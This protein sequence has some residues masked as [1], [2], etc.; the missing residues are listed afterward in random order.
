M[1]QTAP[2][3]TRLIQ[4]NTLKGSRISI[5]ET[6]D[7]FTYHIGTINSSEVGFDN[8]SAASVGLDDLFVLKSNAGNG[9]NSWF[10]TFNAG[11]KGTITPRYVYVDSSE[12]VYIF[13]Q[14][15]GTVTVGNKTISSVNL[16]D[17]FLVKIDSNGNAVW[18]NYL[19]NAYNPAFK[20]KV[21]TDGNDIFFV[22]GG[23][24]LVGLNNGNGQVIYDNNYSG[25]E[26]KSVAIKDQDIYIGG[27][28]LTPNTI[29][30]TEALTEKNTGFILK[31]DKNANFTASLKTT[32]A[33]STITSSDISDIAISSDRYLL[34]SGFYGYR[35]INLVTEAGTVSFSY[36][37]NTNYSG[38]GLFNFVA[39][40]DF[41]LASVSFFR[42]STYINQG[43]SYSISISKSSSRLIAYGNTGNFRQIIRL[44]DKYSKI[45]S[46][47]NT[48][49]YIVNF[50]PDSK[51]DDYTLI[52]SS[53]SNGAYQSDLQPLYY[54]IEMSASG[55]Y[56][57]R[58]DNNIRVFTSGLYNFQNSN[59][60]WAKQKPASAG[61][62]YSQTF[63]KHLNSEKG[64][65]FL[66]TLLEG[67]ANFFGRQVDNG[68]GNYSR[69]F[70]RLGSDGLPKWI[71]KFDSASNIDKVNVSQNYA[72]VDK[73]DNF[74]VFCGKSTGLATFT[75]ALGDSYS[76]TQNIGLYDKVLI[77]LDKNGKL[78]WIKQISG[79]DLS[80]LTTDSNNNIYLTGI[81]GDITIDGSLTVSNNNSLFI[82]KFDQA[83][84]LIYSK[85]YSSV[86][87]DA[88]SMIPVI[89]AQD[90]FYIFSE[91][92][93]DNGLEYNFG[94]INFFSNEYHTDLIMLKFDNN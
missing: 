16:T 25:I 71:A 90:N 14:F 92:I 29:F 43:A 4:Q 41:N 30:G 70:T 11:N 59:P 73:D 28:T 54:G 6:T 88:F 31:G 27:T 15:K 13:A 82:L 48:N 10:K 60:L 46:Y 44:N 81:S 94:N 63:I 47:T 91:P 76:F 56:F 36:N 62:S 7:N 77:K 9:T 38:S 74:Y 26:L 40:V 72:V 2:E 86:I 20:V 49:G 5:V 1:A 89:D 78:I 87:V 50:S 35:L 51:R 58:V 18:I 12:N 21:T 45:S 33:D 64:D 34:L 68:A 84:S 42:S 83:G 67:K 80:A 24:H 17:A 65:L 19:E 52:T 8:L 69:Y 53:D 93:K 32:S 75:D 61:G 39:K 3:I 55:N 37:P 79:C 66:T 57:V 85:A 23:T 22:Y